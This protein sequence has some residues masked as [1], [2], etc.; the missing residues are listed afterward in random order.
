[1]VQHEYLVICILIS[2]N[3]EFMKNMNSSKVLLFFLIA[4]I[5]HSLFSE[6][7]D[8]NA[9]IR[10]ALENNRALQKER[11]A[12]ELSFQKARFAWNVFLPS[13]SLGASFRHIHNFPNAEISRNSREL[14][15][16]AGLSLSLAPG[17]GETVRQVL[18][19][20][21][22]SLTSWRQAEA[23]LVRN[24]QKAYLSLLTE[25]S[26]IALA[27][28]N[29]ELARKQEALVRKNYDNGL[30]SEL[31]LL[32]ASYAA[33]S[34]EPDVEEQKQDW[35]AS[36]RNFNTLLGV[37]IET[38]YQFSDPVFIAV[39]PIL[40]FSALENLI[41][42]RLDIQAAQQAL[43]RA[44]SQK[45][46]G[47]INS[48]A[49]SVQLSESVSVSGLLEGVSLPENGSFS[50]TVSIPLNGYIPGS[51]ERV[52]AMELDA[53]VRTAALSLEQVRTQAR[54]E[55]KGLVDSLQQYRNAIRM[56]EM[57]VTLATRAYELTDQGYRSG[58]AN[59][60]EYD[61]ARKDLLTAQVA[62]LSAR[63]NYVSAV[64]ELAWALNCDEAD[65]FE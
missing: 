13:L 51:R 38:E 3:G 23:L 58:L 37:P 47:L 57:R 20:R 18:L 61:E 33:A 45:R 8:R 54:L 10:I 49:P 15:A 17:A 65:L 1:M 55:V 36:L 16:S 6:T 56:S 62:L 29:L 46:A 35:S 48:H 14:S 12:L 59:Q 19:A 31:E 26:M 21:D 63:N 44:E 64:V 22:T 4:C 43:A 41:E 30:A 40:P 28:K 52:A 32:Q 9:A 50:L 27:E 60:K 7:L 39:R 42:K 53:I 24:V 5:G 25:S 11:I 2:C 34:L